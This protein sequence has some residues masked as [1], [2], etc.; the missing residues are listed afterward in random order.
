MWSI[1]ENIPWGFEKKVYSG[2]FGCNVLTV[3]I[4]SNCFIVFFR[5]SVTLL[6]FCLEDLSIDMSGILK[7]PTSIVFPSI[8][9]FMSVSI[10]CYLGAYML[11]SV[12]SSS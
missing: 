10:L 8:F 9:P 7:S 3:S 12:I 11:M 2:F 5:V 6:I 4:K 1:L